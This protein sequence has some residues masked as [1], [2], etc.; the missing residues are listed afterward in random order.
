MVADYITQ[1]IFHC[2]IAFDDSNDQIPPSAK[3]F[4]FP[5][6]FRTVRILFLK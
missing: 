2:L 5:C 3:S 1:P 4:F 6:D